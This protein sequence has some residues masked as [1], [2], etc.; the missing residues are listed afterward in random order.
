M[1]LCEFD[2]YKDDD[3]GERE[4]AVGIAFGTFYFLFQAC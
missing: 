2:I 1:I 4:S 3:I